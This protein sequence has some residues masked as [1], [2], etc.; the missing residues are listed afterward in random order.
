M[1]KF[2]S[3]AKQWY[4][5]GR[6]LMTMP[7]PPAKEIPDKELTDEQRAARYM[8]RA[9]YILYGEKFNKRQF[10]DMM[11]GYKIEQK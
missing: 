7:E 2:N 1:G 11:N 10:S 3:A 4:W 5:L 8:H 9:F 6:A